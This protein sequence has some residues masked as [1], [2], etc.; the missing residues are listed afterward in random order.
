MN[1]LLTLK[2]VKCKGETKS[3][4][5]SMS[6][7]HTKRSALFHLFRSYKFKQSDE[8]LNELTTLFKG[9]KIKSAVK[10][11]NGNGRIQVG[12]SPLSFAMYR[13]INEYMLKENTSESV[14]G[15]TFLCLTWN[16]ICRSA[17]TVSIHLHHLEW[18]DDCLSIYFAHMKK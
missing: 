14:F 11:Q 8:F 12:K 5:F 17:N 18:M 1:Y 2:R 6:T 9:L 7:Y 10:Q 3:K 15:R 4:P 13:K 16:L